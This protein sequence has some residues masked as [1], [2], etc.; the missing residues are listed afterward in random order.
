[1]VESIMWIAIL[2]IAG[3][4]IVPTVIIAIAWFLSFKLPVTIYQ[5]TGNGLDQCIIKQDKFK[6]KNKR[7]AFVIMFR[8]TRG[9]SP[10]FPGEVWQ[11]YD[12]K[13][14]IK[15]GLSLYMTTEGEFHPLAVTASLIPRIK[16]DEQG[17]IVRDAEGKAMYEQVLQAS[18]KI[19][20]QDNREFIM[21]QTVEITKL[22]MT[23]RERLMTIGIVAIA[24]IIIAAM[25]IISIIYLSD[26]ANNICNLA[27]STGGFVQQ[28]SS[29]VLNYAQGAVGG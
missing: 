18:L 6:V 3:I 14:K 2:L 12:M 19:L 1:M 23:S 9:R 26:M 7:G 5:Q 28:N 29:G 24:A 25:V 16:R 10:S 11:Q 27:P 15:R 21:N 22:T 13:G 20:S 4:I 17:A 8:G